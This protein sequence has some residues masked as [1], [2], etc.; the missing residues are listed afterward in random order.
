MTGSPE[1]EVCPSTGKQQ[2]ELQ[3]CQTT[4]QHHI[5]VCNVSSCCSAFAT[6]FGKGLFEELSSKGRRGAHPALR[7][8][9]TQNRSDASPSPLLQSENTPWLA[10]FLA[11]V[12]KDMAREKASGLTPRKMGI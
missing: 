1:Q 9:T 8:G 10:G 4:V 2:Q 3:V 5:S 12:K 6:L 7:A 11:L